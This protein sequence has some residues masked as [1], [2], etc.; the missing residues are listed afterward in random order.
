MPETIG[1]FICE[2][3]SNIKDSIDIDDLISF[4]LNLEDV[5]IAKPFNVLCSDE[6]KEFIK[7]GITENKLKRLVIAACSPKEHEA[8]FKKIAAEAGLNP[9]LLQ[10]INIREQCAWTTSNKHLA[11]KKAERMLSSGIKR[12][13][14]H[15]PLEAYESDCNTD[16]LVI[17]AGIAGISTAIS[18]AKKNRQVYLV[19]KQPVIGG[20]A[21]YYEKVFPSM[22]CCSC[23]IQPLLNEV[24][25]NENIHLFT[26]SKVESV[27]GY[28]GNFN[29]RI[30]SFPRFV[31]PS[32]CI[33][34]GRCSDVCPVIVK[35]EYSEGIGAR[36]AIYIPTLT[37]VPHKASIDKKNCLHF[38][39]Q[40]CNACVD[41]C[42]F[43][44]INFED[45]EK[46]IEVNV[47]A[48][49]IATGFELFDL[50]N[51]MQY[52][53]G[54]IENI[55]SSLEVEI[56]LNSTVPSGRI[57]LIKDGSQAKDIALI[58]CAG[59]RDKKHIE[60]CSGIC[61]MNLLKI[62]HLLRKQLP[63]ACISDFYIDLC[64]PGKE[65]Q[66]FFNN[67]KEN[68][69]IDFIRIKNH[70]SL[71]ISKENNRISLKYQDI[72]G[73]YR[74]AFFDIVIL[75]PAL[76]PSKDTLRLAR[77]FDITL[78]RN[79]FF[80]E[81]YPIL[82]PVSAAREGIYI[83]G[84]ARSPMA[85]ASAVVDAL[86]VSGRISSTLIHGKKLKIEPLIAEISNDLCSD[87]K[88]C[89]GLCPYG[90]IDY[91]SST[92]TPSVNKVLCQ[93]CGICASSCPSGAIICRHYTDRQIN[94]EITGL[95]G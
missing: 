57:V 43:G 62:G 45:S 16:V 84:C 46:I 65:Y 49:V 21:A 63:H 88:I 5:A 52:G 20:K 23:M 8:T 79:G 10:I 92:K 44:S 90:A 13:H 86:A 82:S 78:D 38:S 25:E 91:N 36:N 74:T 12:V 22:E 67:I 14:F 3:V 81:G 9:F 73:E 31:N 60:Y 32:T 77:L 55:F 47:G 70:D 40:L 72:V 35:D 87:C 17:G 59:S 4:A 95:L 68:D 89:T 41:T 69:R 83:A 76:K 71:V 51:A 93:G 28:F 66:A 80:N 75:A 42:H 94:A 26:C 6:G 7:N 64:L 58:H 50:K 27:K 11:T 2:C 39:E 34:C 15:E 18:L 53:Y 30:K 54:A 33:G 1:V 61:C 24:L 37:A 19:E 56:L 85:M 48:V 29:I